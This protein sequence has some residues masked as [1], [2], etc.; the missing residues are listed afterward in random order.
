MAKRMV[1]VDDDAGMRLVAR[2]FAEDEGWVVV[3]EAEDGLAA[4]DLVRRIVPDVVVMDFHMPELDGIAATRR[5]AR[6][7]PGVS[8]IG[9]STADDPAVGDGFLAAGADAFAPKGDFDALRQKLREA[10]PA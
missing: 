4:V 6:S 5:I 9:W 1:I 3:G 8:V 10:Q 7:R 2:M